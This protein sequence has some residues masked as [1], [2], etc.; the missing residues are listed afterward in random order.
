MKDKMVYKGDNVVGALINVLIFVGNFSVVTDFVVLEDMNAY[1]DD[2]MGDVSVGK[3]F[4]REVKIKAR[5]FEGTIT[6][7]KGDES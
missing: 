2:G 5:W 3:P 6:L 4:L 7:Y 1:R